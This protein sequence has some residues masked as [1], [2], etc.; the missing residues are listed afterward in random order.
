MVVNH[1][2]VE[3]EDD[4]SEFLFHTRG[5][6]KAA[7]VFLEWFRSRGGRATKEEV[8][9]FADSLA[10]GRFS[11]KLSRSNF[12]SS[13]IRNF[14]DAGLVALQPEFDHETRK[15]VRVY[16]AIT[17]PIPQRRPARPSLVYNA[18]V[19]AERWNEQFKNRPHPTPPQVS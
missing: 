4:I 5:S 7:R 14:L 15:V 3:S 17:Q 10:A 11:S 8:S 2:E 16:R 9:D 1:R 19:L 18:H 12:Y 6:R 13:V